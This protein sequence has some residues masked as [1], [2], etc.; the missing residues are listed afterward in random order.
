MRCLRRFQRPA[1]LWLVRQQKDL[2][3]SVMLQFRFAYV[4]IILHNFTAD[5]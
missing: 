4:K 5:D 1:A 3:F 2:L